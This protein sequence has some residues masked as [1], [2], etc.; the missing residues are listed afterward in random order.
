MHEVCELNSGDTNG[1]TQGGKLF[2]S[3]AIYTLLKNCVYLGEVFPVNQKHIVL[4]LI[5]RVTVHVD[6]LDIDLSLDGLMELILELLSDKPDLVAKY[7]QLYASASSH[8]L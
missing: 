1:K 6:R 5:E 2:N 4:Q 7:R 8:G 3:N